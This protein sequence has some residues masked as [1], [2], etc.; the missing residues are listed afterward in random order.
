M[1]THGR[2]GWDRLELGSTA[3]AVVGAAFCP[4]LTVRGS[5][6]DRVPMNLD[7]ISLSRVL[8]PI[9][10]SACAARALAYAGTLAEPLAAHIR[11]L[12]VDEQATINPARAAPV[13]SSQEKAR[14][15]QLRKRLRRRMCTLQRH[16][17]QADFVINA[18][19]PGKVILTQAKECS[20][21]M[22]VMG[23][24]S[25]QGLAHLVFGSVAAYVVRHAACPV[26]TVKIS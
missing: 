1:G 24:N 26:L 9:D 6:T 12:H 23:T 8:V 10:F 17:I 2:T 7:R 18:G 14:Q 3:E 15:L 22:I 16:P 19:S 5:K 21:D 25:R 11:L 20:A 4:V 13:S